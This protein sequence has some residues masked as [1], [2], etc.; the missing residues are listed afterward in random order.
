MIRIHRFVERGD[1]VMVGAVNEFLIFQKME[2]DVS[3]DTDK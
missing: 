1:G 2:W 3:S